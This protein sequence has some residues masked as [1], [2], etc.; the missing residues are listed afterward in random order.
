MIGLLARRTSWMLVSIRAEG[1][2]KLWIP[3]PIWFVGEALRGLWILAWCFPW[4]VRLSHRLA[5]RHSIPL[6]HEI[7]VKELLGQILQ[8]LE[9]VRR[10]GPFTLVEVRDGDNTVSVRL[11]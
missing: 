1:G 10:V 9:A 11:V 8:M 4:L 5:A 6:S 2:P 7:S 3:L